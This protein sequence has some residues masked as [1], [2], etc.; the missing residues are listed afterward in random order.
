M[1]S[2]RQEF[3]DSRVV[4]KLVEVGLGRAQ[5]RLLDL[6]LMGSEMLADSR[7]HLLEGADL[8]LKTGVNVHDY[9]RVF[10]MAQLVVDIGSTKVHAAFLGGDPN[11]AV[12]WKPLFFSR[13]SNFSE[14][15][16]GAATT[17]FESIVDQLTSM[18]ETRMN[19]SNYSLSQLESI[20]IVWSNAIE[21]QP[22]NDR[23]K[24]VRGLTGV[25]PEHRSDAYRKGEWF[26]QDLKPGTDIGKTFRSAFEDRGFKGR[27]FGIANDVVATQ[28]SCFNAAGALVAAYGA[29]CTEVVD[30]SVYVTE[31]GA[32]LIIPEDYLSHG[33]Y[34]LKADQH[35]GNKVALEDL[36]AGKGIPK[37]VEGH[38][39]LLAEG[40]IKELEPISEILLRSHKKG[41]T[42]LT[43]RD[44]HSIM[45][46]RLSH[47]SEL[48][49]SNWLQGRTLESVK[50]VIHYVCDRA[51]ALAGMM[52]YLALANQSASGRPLTL[53]VDSVL[54]RN[55]PS[56]ENAF[57][58][59]LRS[60]MRGQVSIVF[61]RPMYSTLV[62]P[63]M[64]LISAEITVPM[65]GM[66]R[67]LSAAQ[68]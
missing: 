46:G 60:F 45:S 59:V 65:Q 52:G 22:F 28:M 18:V 17:R 41:S 47:I 1:I 40:G 55:L 57:K 33:D 36:I 30:R 25:V 21:G 20:G 8:H 9:V 39:V 44:L 27:S 61:G 50:E 34:L 54:A 19:H 38:I 7:A 4:E 12:S 11:A 67:L 16:D 13:M 53:A 35:G 49:L 58:R 43:G 51:G 6:S 3:S 10:P 37:I 14:P 56:Y 68:N 5:D 32:K 15:A 66:P 62:D 26:V 42:V 63:D 23:P 64:G 29:N 2:R 31:L 48:E 24:N